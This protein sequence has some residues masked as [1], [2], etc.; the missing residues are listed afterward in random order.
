MRRAIEFTEHSAGGAE[1]LR[2]AVDH[3]DVEGRAADD[4]HAV[5]HR[6]VGPRPNIQRDRVVAV[7]GEVED[8][9]VGVRAG[10]RRGDQ[11]AAFSGQVAAVVEQAQPQVVDRQRA[12]DGHDDAGRLAGIERK[13]EEVHVG[14][15]RAGARVHARREAADAGQPVDARGQPEAGGIEVL[16]VGAAAVRRL[17][18]TADFHPL[19]LHAGADDHRRAV[20][21]G[22]AVKRAHPQPP[23]AGRTGG[24]VRDHQRAAG[25]VGAGARHFVAIGVDQYQLHRRQRVRRLAELGTD[26][27]GEA[28]AVAEAD[29][30]LVDVGAARQHRVD[31]TGEDQRA[32]RR[33]RNERR[34]D[35]GV[36]VGGETQRQWVDGGGC[37]VGVVLVAGQVL[38]VPFRQAKLVSALGQCV[39][40]LDRQRAA[41]VGP[42]EVPVQRQR[43]A[44]GVEEARLRPVGV[45]RLVEG[46]GD[47]LVGRDLDRAARRG[48]YQL[49]PLGIDREADLEALGA[50]AGQIDEGAGLGHQRVV[51]GGQVV[52]Q[53]HRDAGVGPPRIELNVAEGVARFIEQRHRAH[54]VGAVGLAQHQVLPRCGGADQP[55]AERAGLQQGCRVVA[56]GA[57][58]LQQELAIGRRGDLDRDARARGSQYDEALTERSRH[59]K[60]QQFVAEFAQH[61]H[62]R[63]DV[64]PALRAIGD[65]RDVD[66]H[67]VPARVDRGVEA[68]RAADRCGV[69]AGRAHGGERRVLDRRQLRGGQPQVAVAVGVEAGVAG[70]DQ[71]VVDRIERTGGVPP[72]VDLQEVGGVAVGDELRDAQRAVPLHRCAGAV[73]DGD[74]VAGAVQQLHEA[75]GIGQ[76]GLG[77]QRLAGR[78]I[79]PVQVGVGPPVALRRQPAD[80][81]GS[82]CRWQWQGLPAVEPL[83]DVGR[84]V[85]VAAQPR[86][87]LERSVDGDVQRPTDLRR[88]ARLTGTEAHRQH[89]ELHGVVA[90]GRG[91]HGLQL[92][93]VEGGV[94]GHRITIGVQQIQLDAIEAGQAVVVDRSDGADRLAGGQVDAVRLADRQVAR[95]AG[96][97][98]AAAVGHM[99]P[100]L[101]RADGV[102]RQRLGAARDD[103]LDADDRR[104]GDDVDGH[105]RRAARHQVGRQQQ[106]RLER[107]KQHLAAERQL[108]HHAR[109]HRPASGRPDAGANQRAVDGACARPG[110]Q[111]AGGGPVQ[112]I[113]KLAHPTSPSTEPIGRFRDCRAAEPWR[114]HQGTRTLDRP[115]VPRRRPTAAPTS[116]SPASSI[117]TVSGSGTAVMLNSMP[118]GSTL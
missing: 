13:A 3:A 109:A 10:D 98:A 95:L 97:Q 96:E 33:A 91:R 12:F 42:Q 74:D 58:H 69:G 52:G 36:A 43:I 93:A 21:P 108:A 53:L 114:H 50:L 87:G 47:G 19:A 79:D 37:G 18:V 73:G 61:P 44:F 76:R 20:Q 4:D 71:R 99:H 22:A 5:A 94:A 118:A 60:D 11:H 23:E 110:R 24:D 77:L 90:V 9:P 28:D 83:G 51:A 17:Q 103:R 48:R 1:R 105:W 75:L 81:G 40:Q 59:G 31:R 84:V 106:S 88:I 7:V 113:N 54:A 89:G 117:A 57:L 16:G 107:L 32:Q 29:L 2:Q 45:H 67:R 68:S 116:P 66:Q 82:L 86:L 56:A 35:I 34:H 25:G 80:D 41:V 72:Q 63:Q 70:H 27:R 102:H 115:R 26:H 112:Q 55:V 8:H 65:R 104:R 78:E 46:Q 100:A 14:A 92:R 111:R 30:E 39:G 64:A 85:A 49:R 62:L 6:T 38:Q 15:G 101:D